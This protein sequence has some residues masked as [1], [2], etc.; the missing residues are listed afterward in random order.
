MKLNLNPTT[1]ITL[2]LLSLAVTLLL[3]LDLLLGV[4]PDPA[5]QET[6]AR[7]QFAE[8]IAIQV[9][10]LLMHDSADTAAAVLPELLQRD[11]RLRSI[12]VRTADMRLLL[13]TPSHASDWAAGSDDELGRSHFIVP[14]SAGTASTG[15]W[16][17]IEV[18]FKPLDNSLFNL[19]S[20][21]VKLIL[22]FSLSGTL[23]YYLYLRR[24]LLHL[25]PSAAIPERVQTAFDAMSEA[26]VV[27]D[28]RKR[29]VMVNRSFEKMQPDPNEQIISRPLESITW[30][31]KGREHISGDTPWDECMRSKQP[32]DSGVYEARLADGKLRRL[33]TTASPVLDARNAVRGCLVSFNDVTDLDEA[34][35]LL[36]SLMADLSSSKELLEVQN[37]ELQRLASV[38]PMTGTRN[39]RS[40]FPEFERM[41]DDARG[42]SLQLSFIMADIDKFKLVNDNY[43]HGIGDKVIQKFAAIMLREARDTDIVCRY[44]GEE[45]CI[46]LPG[47][48]AEQAW[49]VAERIRK[50]VQAEVGAALPLDPQPVI[51]TSF[52]VSTVTAGAASADILADQA[53]Q[54][55]YYSKHNGRNR[56]T[57]YSLVI[58]NAAHEEA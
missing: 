32:S 36:V 4:F 1:R 38:D 10:S 20:P 7:K 14:I 19:L 13:A 49:Q 29:I 9:A 58:A 55:L 25:D 42:R 57:T 8:S 47:T 11:A 5:R 44:G 51:T 39:R 3:A 24:T 53:D 12:G 30:L 54:A 6:Q 33:I 16:G 52:G 34:N 27:L 48:D 17:Q 15:N 56:C 26:I 43:G 21:G 40:F 50:A 28:A 23:I 18:S 46:A 41:F 45:F 2:G 35:H 37:A 22:I 31:G